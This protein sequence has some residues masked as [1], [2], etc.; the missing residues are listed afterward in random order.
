MPRRAPAADPLAALVRDAAALDAK[1]IDT[2]YGLEPVYEPGAESDGALRE[3]VEID[4]PWCGEVSGLHVDLTADDREV[5]EDCQVCCA[6]MTIALEVDA[7]GALVA[8]T[9][10]R[11]A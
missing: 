7:R 6:P 11:A 1:R 2:L 8:V 3:F 5:I 4:C 9:S 10:R